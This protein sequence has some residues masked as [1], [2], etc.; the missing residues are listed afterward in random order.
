MLPLSETV[1]RAVP[2]GPTYTQTRDTQ[3]TGVLDAI[4]SEGWRLE[5]AGY[6]YRILESVSRDKFFSSGQREAMSGEIVGVYL[7]RRGVKNPVEAG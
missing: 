1:G 6:V 7:F 2:L 3:D 4:E 5:H